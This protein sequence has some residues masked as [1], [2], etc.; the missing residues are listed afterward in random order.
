MVSSIIDAFSAGDL[1]VVK[2]SSS[3]CIVLAKQPHDFLYE[4][5]LPHLASCMHVP[6]ICAAAAVAVGEDPT[7]ISKQQ[8]FARIVGAL[9]GRAAEEVIFGEA[10]VTSGASGDLQ[11]V[12]LSVWTGWTGWLARIGACMWPAAQQIALSAPT[13]AFLLGF[14]GAWIWAWEPVGTSCIPAALMPCTPDS[15]RRSV[16]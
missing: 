10:E 8:I 3:E 11:Q 14:S 2:P 6:H 7:L 4:I 12:R 15:I 13:A 1:C 16:L 9:G 5:L